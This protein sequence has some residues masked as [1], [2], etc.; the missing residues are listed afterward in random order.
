MLPVYIG[1]AEFSGTCDDC[2]QE[3]MKLFVVRGLGAKEYSYICRDC[4]DEVLREFPGMLNEF[5][6][7]RNKQQLRNERRQLVKE[8]AAIVRTAR[9][10]SEK[11]LAPYEVMA[12]RITEINKILLEERR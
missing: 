9:F 5:I 12:D 2:E 7:E 11:Q 8:I 4:F 1:K 10:L 3:R 6:G